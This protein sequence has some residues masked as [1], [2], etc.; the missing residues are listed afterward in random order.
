MNLA[1]NRL[2]YWKE[3]LEMYKDTQY[4]TQ[5]QVLHEIEAILH[6]LKR[7]ERSISSV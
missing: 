4:L 1:Q 6:E 2:S 7:A 3:R 5:T